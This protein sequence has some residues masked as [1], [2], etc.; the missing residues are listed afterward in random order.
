MVA[1]AIYAG[2]PAK[3]RS[4]E[5]NTETE[6]AA[7]S[8]WEWLDQDRSVHS[9]FGR[10]LSRVHAVAATCRH[11]TRPKDAGLDGLTGGPIPPLSVYVLTREWKDIGPDMIFGQNLHL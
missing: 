11:L 3:R 8:V 5:L 7:A 2:V 1:S 4:P 10:L 9:R 6:S